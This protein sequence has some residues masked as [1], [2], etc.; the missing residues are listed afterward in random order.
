MVTPNRTLLSIMVLGAVITMV[1]GTGIFAV[2]SDRAL[3]GNNDVDSGALAS[4]ADIQVAVAS[5][6][7]DFVFECGTYQEDLTLPLWS[8]SDVQPGDSESQYLCVKNVGSAARG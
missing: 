4:A 2:F 6:D 5:V 3:V 8:M 1:G 7:G